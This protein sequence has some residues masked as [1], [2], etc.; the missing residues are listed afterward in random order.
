MALTIL[1]YFVSIR[2]LAAK[3]MFLGEHDAYVLII[4]VFLL[5][6]SFH[7]I[8]FSGFLLIVLWN[9]SIFVEMNKEK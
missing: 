7:K 2:S 8:N 6:S 5:K 9:N 3:D 4:S 1:F